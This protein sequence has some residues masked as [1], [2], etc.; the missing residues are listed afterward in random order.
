MSILLLP[1]TLFTFVHCTRRYALGIFRL[2]QEKNT[3]RKKK[4]QLHRDGQVV[5]P[6]RTRLRLARVGGVRH[7]QQQKHRLDVG[8]IHIH[9]LHIFLFLNM[10]DISLSWS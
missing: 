1:R 6:N 2:K 7:V 10:G 3:Y 5:S 9:L 4:E 8:E